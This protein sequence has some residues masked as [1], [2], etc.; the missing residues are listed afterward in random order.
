M[1]KFLPVTAVLVLLFFSC[2][3]DGKP[4]KENPNNTRTKTFWAQNLATTVHYQLQAELLAEGTYC[5]VWVEKNSG[6]SANT[7]RNMANAYD[8]NIYQKMID[9]FSIRNFT[10]SGYNFSNIM[11]LADALTDGDGKLTILLLDIK[12]GYRQGVN[13]SYVAGYFWAGNFYPPDL[14]PSVTRYSNQC[15]MIY[16]DI[17]PGVPGSDDSNMTLAHEMQHLMNFVT[18]NVK[19]SNGMDLWID[20]G[21]SSAAEWV[22]LGRHDQSKLNWFNNNGVYDNNSTKV[23]SSSI[24]EGNNFFVWENRVTDSN[25][26]PILDDYATVYFFFQWLRLQAGE[27]ANTLALQ[28]I[29]KDIIT[30]TQYNH[31]A[32]LNALNAKAQENYSDWGTLLKTWLAANY[33]NAPGG[34][35]GY[36]SELV[37]KDLKA[38]TVAPGTTTVELYPGEGVY[39]ITN[40]AGSTNAQGQNIR[41]AGLKE[42]PAQVSDD[43]VYAGG[44]LLTYNINTDAADA[45][46]QGITT[47]VA[48]SV[49]AAVSAAASAASGGRSALPFTGPYRIGAGDLLRRNGKDESFSGFNFSVPLREIVIHE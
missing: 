16:V 48:A 37:L 36:R 7:A 13:D 45:Q 1:K 25:P 8:N 40:S 29:Y 32:V 17:S 34:P 6:V 18:S 12:D 19:R 22:Y 39:S 26:Y 49:S 30:S 35:Y 33:I 27:D 10:Y 9:V 5:K 44:A 4:N 3:L 41:Y 31:T 14:M 15:D 21:L 47:G 43:N 2:D 38:P 11:E 42:S 46:E 24:D 28:S 23:I 20:E